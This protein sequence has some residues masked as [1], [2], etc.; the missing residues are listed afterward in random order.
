MNLSIR[1]DNKLESPDLR[2]MIERRV[3]AVLARL[4]PNF[5]SLS[6]SLASHGSRNAGLVECR[7]SGSLVRGD[8]LHLRCT[9]PNLRTA[10]DLALDRFRRSTLRR[11]NRIRPTNGRPS[12]L[13]RSMPPARLAG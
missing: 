4:S 1:I 8:T 9:D 6:V 12:L 5:Q 10:T 3:H 13:P 7:I 11:L 2:T